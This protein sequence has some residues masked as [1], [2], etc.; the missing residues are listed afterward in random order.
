MNDCRD[1]KQSLM[2]KIHKSKKSN[3]ACCVRIACHELESFYLGDL[4]AVK[5]GLAINNIQTSYSDPDSIQNPSQLLK[6][7]TRN[8]YKKIAGSRKIA[9]YLNL[10]GRNCSRSFNALLY[11]LRTLTNITLY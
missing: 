2:Q 7:I 11:G 8:K 9:H 5:N 6:K 4:D 3:S 10:D 1:I